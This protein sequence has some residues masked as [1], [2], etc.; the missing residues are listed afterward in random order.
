MG[1][2][3]H[4]EQ[5]V[6]KRPWYLCVG[7]TVGNGGLPTALL[8]CVDLCARRARARMGAHA[9]NNTH[10]LINDLSPI[11]QNLWRMD[12]VL[13]YSPIVLADAEDGLAEREVCLSPPCDDVL[14]KLPAAA[15]A[16]LDVKA[17]LNASLYGSLRPHLFGHLSDEQLMELTRFLDFWDLPQQWLQMAQAE[18]GARGGPWSPPWMPTAVRLPRGLCARRWSRCS[19]RCPR[20]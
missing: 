12:V 16:R 7:V 6:K 5:L 20:R 10:A 2:V 1:N 19:S 17:L 18:R 4:C 14:R 13:L 3:T 11:K 15:A 8:G 9:V